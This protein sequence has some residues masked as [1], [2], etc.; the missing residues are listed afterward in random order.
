M[1]IVWNGEKLERERETSTEDDKFLVSYNLW[2]QHLQPLGICIN[3]FNGFQLC[4]YSSARVVKTHVLETWHEIFEKI[5][6]E[7]LILFQ[8]L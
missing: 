1:Y 3:V 8:K 7:H 2:M 5:K 4:A 6:D